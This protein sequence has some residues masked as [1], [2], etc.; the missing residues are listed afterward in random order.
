MLYLLFDI[1]CKFIQVHKFFFFIFIEEKK[2]L[3]VK[4]MRIVNCQIK[5]K[6]MNEQYGSRVNSTW[7]MLTLIMKT[8]KA[9]SVYDN[10]TTH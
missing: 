2:N 7:N 8:V 4:K 6:W 5:H 9:L 3:K 10:L 1:H